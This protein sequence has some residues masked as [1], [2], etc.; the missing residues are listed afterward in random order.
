[1][2]SDVPS[3]GP[4]VGFLDSGIGGLSVWWEALRILPGLST[5]YFADRSHCPYGPRPQKEVQAL[6]EAGVRRL[7]DAGCEAVV[8]AC[9]TAT[10]A[11]VDALR[12][13]LPRVPFIGMEPAVKPA[14]LRSKSGA[15][16]ILATSGTFRGRLFLG[17]SAR[18][19]KGV[20]LVARAADDLV[21]FVE[22]G[23]LDSPALRTALAA[24]LAPM[25][26][27]GADHIVLGCTHFPF[28]APV[29]AELAGPGV[30][31][32]NPAAAVARQLARVLDLPAAEP[33]PGTLP[34][35]HELLSRFTPD[36][37][38]RLLVS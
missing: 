8:L 22:R 17:T 29:L 2:L 36:G 12:T 3:A 24:H 1:M 20:R 13:A 15:I 14:A 4:R 34:P 23:E 11:A 10:A 28:L 32:V 6:V 16:G 35:P 27:A 26:E 9:N 30:E 21:P 33:V 18:Y 19:A 31:L 38:H 37:A 25:R 7:L 5:V